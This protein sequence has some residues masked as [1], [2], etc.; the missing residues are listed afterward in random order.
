MDRSADSQV[1]NGTRSWLWP[2]LTGIVWGLAEATWFFI[3]PDVLLCY[4]GLRSGKKALIATL[5]VVAGAMIGAVFLYGALD[6]IIDFDGYA[7]LHHIWGNFPGFRQKMAEVA[8]GHLRER[9][10]LGLLS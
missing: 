10:A 3:V 9:S 4:W 6:W 7:K 8:A 1:R 2:L 5:A